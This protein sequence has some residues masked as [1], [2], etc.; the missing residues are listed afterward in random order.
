M[1]GHLSVG[2]ED[3]STVLLEMGYAVPYNEHTRAAQPRVW[4]CANNL[5][6]EVLPPETDSQEV[7]PDE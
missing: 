2:G 4:D 6:E 1:V 5:V 3:L 7:P